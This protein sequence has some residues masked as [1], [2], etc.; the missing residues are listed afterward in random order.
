MKVSA[1]LLLGPDSPNGIRAQGQ[2]DVK[3]SI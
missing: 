1:S 2:R 3:D